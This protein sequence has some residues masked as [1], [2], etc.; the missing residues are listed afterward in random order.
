MTILGNSIVGVLLL[1]LLLAPTE[2]AAVRFTPSEISGVSKLILAQSLAPYAMQ[3][4]YPEHLPI[5][6]GNTLHQARLTY[7]LDADLELMLDKIYDRYEPDY[8]AFV[9]IDAH[10][11]A[12][13]AMKSFIKEDEL[14]GNL[15]L[16][17]SFPAASVFKVVTAAAALDRDLLEPD[18][19]LRYNGKRTSL[20]KKQVLRHKDNK[21][22]R[23]PTLKKAFAES[24]NTVFARIGIYT[25]GADSLETYARRFAFNVPVDTDIYF[26]TG[27][28]EIE[29]D[30][31]TIA[32][33]ASGYTRSNTLSPLHGAMMAAAIVG[34]GEMMLPYVV[35]IATDQWGVPLYLARPQ[36]LGR[37]IS[38]ATAGELQE[39][40]HETVRRGSARKSFRRF[41]KGEF[42]NMSVGGKTGSLSGKSPAGRYD[43]FVGYA[44]DGDRKIGYASLTINKEYWTVKSH[45]VARKFIEAAFNKDG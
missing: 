36:S 2:L 16:R 33:A 39:L 41:F 6:T 44:T 26:E 27:T 20:Y 31:W 18:S 25:V 5:D 32:E 21:W 9:A 23:R 3:D 19:V 34:D 28:T 12:V 37:P 35:S 1:Y 7:T 24:I 17:A 8:G 45:Y 22:T 14:W 42:E 30:E 38:N 40:M 13:I 29:N 10:T 43:W 11:G 15:A 4:E